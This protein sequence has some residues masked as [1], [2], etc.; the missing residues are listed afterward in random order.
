MD[1][2]RAR[3]G[4]RRRNGPRPWKWS[5]WWPKTNR[6]GASSRRGKRRRRRGWR[7][8]FTSKSNGLKSQRPYWYRFKAGKEIS[9]VGV[10]SPRPSPA[11]RSAQLKFAFA[12]CQHWEAGL[13]TAYEHM[14][15]E[16]PDLVVHLG[17]YI[18]EGPARADGRAAAQQP[19]D[20]VAVRLPQPPRA[21]Q[22]RPG[23][24]EDA[25]ALP[26]DPDLGRP[27]SGQQLRRRRARRQADARRRSWN[28]APTPTRPTTSTCRCASSSL[29]QGSKMQMYRRVPFGRSGRVHRA[30]HA[31]VP[32]RPAL[33]RRHE[34]RPATASSI[35]RPR[36]WATRR[37]PG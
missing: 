17:D 33:R 26:V 12:S 10:P 7:I 27:R 14:L 29:P 13:W 25:R 31:A 11:K 30:G 3:S 34:G 32:H 35:P 16:D 22:D 36:S 6:C 37:K 15:A 1:T 28:A 23:H 5:G 4:E 9:P 20:H 19:R 2:P 24:P 18:Y 8:P 21:L